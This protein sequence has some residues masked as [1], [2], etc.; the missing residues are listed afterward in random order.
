MLSIEYLRQIQSELK[1]YLSQKYNI[2]ENE[3]IFESFLK[4][5]L[6]LNIYYDKGKAS[7]INDYFVFEINNEKKIVFL[8][9]E[10][11]KIGENK[12]GVYV[13]VQKIE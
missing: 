13:T 7:R 8:L 3:I 6:Y 10:Y 5:K 4:C 2:N 12:V 1:R 11:R 9:I